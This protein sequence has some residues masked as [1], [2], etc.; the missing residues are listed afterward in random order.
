MLASDTLLPDEYLEFNLYSTWQAILRENKDK[1]V[2][3]PEV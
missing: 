2:P 1:T 3:E